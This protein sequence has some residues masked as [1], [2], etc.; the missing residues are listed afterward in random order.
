MANFQ[1]GFARLYAAIARG[2]RPTACTAEAV[3]IEQPLIARP[4]SHGVAL[5]HPVSNLKGC[6]PSVRS[7]AC[8][9]GSTV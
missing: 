7:P 4:A 8:V 2:A 6:H 1:S 9:T 5:G 3:T